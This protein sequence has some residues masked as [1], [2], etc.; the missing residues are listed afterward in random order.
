MYSFYCK[1]CGDSF[2]SSDKHEVRLYRE[3]HKIKWYLAGRVTKSYCKLQKTLRNTL[4]RPQLA[5]IIN[6]EIRG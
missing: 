2:S 1:N 4:A 6:E 5:I 3:N